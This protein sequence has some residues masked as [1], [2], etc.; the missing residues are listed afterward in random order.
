MVMEHYTS[1]YVDEQGPAVWEKISG[2][3]WAIRP[4]AT[5]LRPRLSTHLNLGSKLWMQYSSGF[6]R[7]TCATYCCV[8]LTLSARIVVLEYSL[9]EVKRRHSVPYW[10]V[11]RIPICTKYNVSLS[12]HRSAKVRELINH[13]LVPLFEWIRGKWVPCSLPSWLMTVD[14]RSHKHKGLRR[15]LFYVQLG[16]QKR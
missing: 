14:W 12:V 16:L 5:Y 8:S 11:D 6:R 9:Y 2:L 1:P 10:T 13:E 7:E 15:F 3:A 4:P